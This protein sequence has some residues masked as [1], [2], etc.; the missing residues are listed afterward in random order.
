MTLKNKTL[1]GLKS[2]DITLSKLYRYE[3]LTTHNAKKII[4][5]LRNNNR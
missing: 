2:I 4:N 5:A 1:N 3:L